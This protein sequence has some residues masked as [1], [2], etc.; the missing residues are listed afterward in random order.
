MDYMDF[1]TK[2][3]ARSERNKFESYNGNLD[4]VPDEMKAFYRS[5]NPVHVIIGYYGVSIKLCPVE[6]LQELQKEYEYLKA[7]LV[8]ATCN[9][10]PIFL[11][12]DGVYTCPHGINEPQLEKKAESFDEYLKGLVE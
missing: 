10:D 2:I 4:F 5:S 1:T 6:E 11:N 12:A 7:Q 3:T 9:G 8:F